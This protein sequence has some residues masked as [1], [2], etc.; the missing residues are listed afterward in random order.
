MTPYIPSRAGVLLIGLAAAIFLIADG[1]ACLA[2]PASS[3]LNA[4]FVM[5]KRRPYSAL[6]GEALKLV[7]QGGSA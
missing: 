4:T 3:F 2:S 5:G 1:R 6:S 7:R